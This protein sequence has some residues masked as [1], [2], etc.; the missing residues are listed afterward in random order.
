M[1]VLLFL[2]SYCRVKYA[3]KS[4]PSRTA[5]T[6]WSADILGFNSTS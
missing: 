4:N 3:L 1:T 5:A 6:I 2:F